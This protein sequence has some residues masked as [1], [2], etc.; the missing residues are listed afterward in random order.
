MRAFCVLLFW[1]FWG[2][3]CALQ[4]W[5]RRVVVQASG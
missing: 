1:V 4:G 2:W 5:W 3:C